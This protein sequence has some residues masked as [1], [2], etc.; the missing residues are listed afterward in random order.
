MKEKLRTSG[1]D[2]LGDVPWGTHFCQFYQTK[3]DLLDILIPYFK[4]GLESNEFCM[5]VTAKPLDEKEAE[6]SLRRAVPDLGLYLRRG[7][8]EIIPHTDWYLKGGFFDSQRVLS[9]WVDKLNRALTKGYEGLR[10]TGNT[11]W[12]EKE[13]WNDFL[14]YEDEVNSVIDGYRMIAICTYSLDKCRSAEVIDVVKTHQFAL[15]KREGR[16]DLIESSERRRATEALKQ[17]EAKY[18]SL[19][20]NMIDGFAFHKIIVD[21]KGKPV[22]YVFLEVNVAFERLTGLKRNGILGK[23]VKEALPGI[24][25]DPADWIGAYGKVALTGKEVRFEQFAEPLGKWF[26]VTAYSPMREYFVTVFEDITDRKRAEQALRE[27]EERLNRSQEIAHLGS[28]ELDLVNN[29]LSWSDEVYRIFGLQPQEFGATYAAFLEAVHPDDRAAVDA[30]YSGSLH[31]GRDTY[32]IEHRVV[33]K[34]TGEVRI[35]HEKCGHIRDGS[36]R[37]I[38]SVG[39]VHD[40]TDRKRA[41][42]SLRKAHAELEA[43]VRE[44]TAELA[45]TVNT[46]QTEVSE[47]LRAE[48]ALQKSAEEI[49]DL[50]NRAPCGY[51]SLDKDGVFVQI[52]DTELQWLGYTRDEVV[53]K[54][55]LSDILTA[56]SVKAFE[57][58][59]RHFKERGWVKDVEYELRRKDGTFLP[60]LL[61]ATTVRD[62][63]G[64]YV[65]SRSTLYDVTER[66]E[67]ERR[68]TVTNELL[69]LYTRT[70]LRKEYL[71]SAM[72]I[73]R[74]WSGCRSVGM[75]IA[76]RDGNI[77]Y[78]ACAGFRPE[79]L[80][81]ERVLSLKR[82]QCACTRVVAGAPEPQDMQAMT[83]AGSFYSN[84]SMKFVE[85]LTD[86]QKARFRGVCIRSGFASVAVVPI[87][88]RDKVLG[89]IHLADEREGLVPL[90]NVEF[91]EQLA[92]IIGEAVFRF[93]I[94][95]EIWTLN[96]ELEQR[97]IERTA[98]LEAA[99]KELEAFAYSVSHDLRA[100]LR[101]ID[102]F[103]RAI[104]EDEAH[105]LDDTG[106]DY[107]RRVRAAAEKMAQLI[108]AL[109]SLSRQTRGEPHRTTVD[110]GSLAKAAADDLR[111]TQPD[112]RVEFVIADGITVQGDAV[113]LRAALE[114]LLGNAWKFTGKCDPARI[115]FGVMQQEEK[116][117]YFVRDNGAG[118]DMTYAR[119][120]FTA[121]QRLHTTDEFPGLGIGLA[122]VQRIVHR[123]GGRIWA[124][125][126]VDKGA[127]F[128]F[129]L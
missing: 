35:V 94:E 86:E 2:V 60:I 10:L 95:E 96:R 109:L 48:A 89:A 108:D 15:T 122:T 65:M 20:E 61:S 47:R 112:R 103:T 8:I 82:D 71:D 30:A 25:N 38:R 14:A 115:E 92:F 9:G 17:S 57:V 11:F 80:E 129:T 12:L 23:R 100:P 87:R 83:R 27:S 31:E 76:D 13:G 98:Q 116:N 6:E 32:E 81:S 93:G 44:R 101:I 77:P 79:F 56:E 125:G 69:K 106:K 72:K 58:N 126:E 5:W 104:E 21:G 24:E 123:H 111:K 37:I 88:Y 42:E 110:M 39:M 128:Y 22:D 120:L 124:E 51:H 97:V 52:N 4:A 55:K 34:A 43:R 54:M 73:I 105:K 41:E 90:K 78:E 26:S 99:N 107:F 29:R 16:W 1:I 18:R 121:F 117:T 85:D 74:E 53:G 50:Y 70:S 113:M 28:W 63:N 91:I 33:R 84:N 7:Q 59:F 127:T 64:N 49:Q 62:S 119:K 102:G 45:K 67:T 114:N 46:L 75:R 68:I 19:F 118:F 3:D 36:G 66:R 40:I